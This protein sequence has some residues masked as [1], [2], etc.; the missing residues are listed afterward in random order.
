ME[1]PIKYLV[2]RFSLRKHASYG[3]HRLIPL[4]KLHSAAVYIA[5]TAEYEA[6]CK[7]VNGFFTERGIPVLILSPTAEDLNYAGYMKQQARMPE[8]RERDEEL[9]ISLSVS[10]EDFASEYEARCSPARFKIGCRQLKGDVFDMTVSPPEGNNIT[11]TELFNS[12]ITYLST[13]K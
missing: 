10:A 6:V 8:G 11:L 13:I 9:F 12:I 3:E 4:D 7:A 1:N 2:R 5:K